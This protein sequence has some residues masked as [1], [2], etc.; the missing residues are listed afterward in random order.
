[1][2][3]HTRPICRTCGTQYAAPRPDCPICTDERQ[4]VPAA[5]QQWT[6]FDE[7]RADPDLSARIEPEGPGLTGIGTNPRFAIGQRAL[8]V[9]TPNGNILWDCTAYLTEDIITEVNNQGGLHAIAISHPHYYTTMV[10][11]SH[12]FNAPIHLHENDAQWIGR[13][14]PNIHLWSGTHTTLLDEVTLINLGVHFAGGTVLHWR[15]TLLT[16]DIVQVIPDRSHV[17]F[18]YSYPNLIPERPAVVRRAAELLKPLD[19]S[20]IYGAWWDSK[21]ETNAHEIVQRS[22]ERYL[23]YT[24]EN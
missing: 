22:A 20:T 12:T 14:D 13:P 3:S 6:D 16:G 18:M 23:A 4:Y 17:A 15:H 5:G 21:I 2:A 10:E 8:L 9:N 11:W 7:L 19:F 24:R 1:M